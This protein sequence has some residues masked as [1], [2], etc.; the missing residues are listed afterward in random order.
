MNLRDIPNISPIQESNK[1][2]EQ[3][4]ATDSTE[5][6]RMLERLQNISGKEDVDKVDDTVEFA[7]AMQKADDDF[8]SIMDLR[9]RLE[10]AFQGKQA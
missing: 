1:P 6:R 7:K 8:S 4:Q 5:F 9:K 3:A 2:A 10:E